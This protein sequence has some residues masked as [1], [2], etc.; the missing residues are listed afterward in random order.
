MKSLRRLG[1]WT[2]FILIFALGT[3]IFLFTQSRQGRNEFS[4][5]HEQ[6]NVTMFGGDVRIGE[7]EQVMG[8]LLVVGDDLTLEGRIGGNLVVV[9]GDAELTG[10]ARV[11][12]NVSVVGGDAEVNDTSAIGGNVAVVGGD[13][14][15]TGHARVGGSVRVVGG[16]IK[17]DPAVHVSGEVAET[18][19]NQAK[20]QR[21]TAL[22]AAEAARDQAK[23][24]REAAL[25]AAKAARD[26]AKLQSEAALEAAKAARDQAK[27]QREAALAAAEA[28]RDQ[29]ASIRTPWF[30]VFL[31]KLVQAFLWTLL[32]TALVL[33]FYW[34][35]PK[36]VKAVSK[37][38]EKETALSFAAGAIGIVGSAILTAILTITICFAL[39][40][41]PLLALLAL[42]VLCGWTVTC[43]WLGRRL[44]ELVAGPGELSWNPMISVGLSSLVITGVTAFSWVIFPCLGFIVALLIGSTGTGAAVVHVAR[45][46]GRL[47]GSVLGNGPNGP[48]PDREKTA[49]DSGAGSAAQSPGLPELD[50]ETAGLQDDEQIETGE[51]ESPPENGEPG[52]E[53]SPRE[54]PTSQDEPDDLTRV[55]GIGPVYSRR[56]QDAGIDR[57][58]QL[59]ALEVQQIAEI[60]GCSASRVERERLRENARELADQR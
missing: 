6:R 8:N 37:T 28:A 12:G 40:A 3:F 41:L 50:D 29:A 24:Q 59:A 57:F 60:L 39:L 30:L 2:T 48:E 5:R 16:R 17:Q 49:T 27:L 25:E 4:V 18:T 46:S 15:L 44:D 13:V 19:R 58:F 55:T 32:I 7:D 9:G 11:G 43:Y 53:V 20:Q 33:L 35:L 52:T 23:L 26:Q 21:E 42:V 31:R 54:D 38:A 47:S 1:C 56:L 22:A 36:Q 45:G 10:H 34:L 14:D 51:V